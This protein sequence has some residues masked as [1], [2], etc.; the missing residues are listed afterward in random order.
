VRQTTSQAPVALMARRGA[1]GDPVAGVPLMKGMSFWEG[2]IF[3]P[4]V[5]TAR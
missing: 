3:I 4:S 5:E 2:K 1:R